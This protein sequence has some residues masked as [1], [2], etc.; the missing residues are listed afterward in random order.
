[1]TQRLSSLTAAAIS[2]VL[3]YA[4]FPGASIADHQK[5]PVEPLAAYAKLDPSGVT[6]SGISSGAFFAHQFHVAYSSLVKGAG[7]VAGGPYGCA[8]QEDSITTPL[9]NPFIVAFVPRR[10]VVSLAVCTHFGRSDFKQAGWGFPDKPDASDLRKAAIRAHAEGKIDDPGN[11]AD[12][13]VWLFHGDKDVGVPKSTMQEL[14]SFYEL[15]GVPAANIETMEGPDARHGMPIKARPAEAS[16]THCML[17]DPS[18]LVRCDYG[19]AELLLRHLY[20]GGSSASASPPGRIV[21]FDQTEFFDEREKSTSLHESG[22]LYVP[23]ACENG[24]A[25]GAKCRLHVAFHGC[26]QSVEKIHELFF[27][28]AGYNAWADANHVIVLYPQ[29]TAWLRLAD[30]SQI[31]GNPKGCWDWWGYSGDDYLSR[32]GKQMRAVREMIGRMLP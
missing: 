9:G 24:S 3:A 1:M 29:A 18:Y 23:S 8:D 20:P 26:E 14:R 17:P 4:V 27:R 32:K 12:S 16:G 15:M 28:D 22:Y 19:A 2:A 5:I 30:P 21:G 11:L 31:S 7:I 6:V 13:R 10:V 25:S